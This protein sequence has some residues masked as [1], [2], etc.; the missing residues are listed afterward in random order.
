M[1]DDTF[2]VPVRRSLVSRLRNGLVT[3]GD[4]RPHYVVCGSDPLVYTVLEELAGAGQRVRVTAIVPPTL[5]SDV[6]DLT[7]IRGVRVVHAERLDER[8]FRSAGLA[9]ADALA[10]IHP[11]DVANLHSALCAQAV[12]PDL[13]LVIRMFNTSLGFGVK[14]LFADCAILSDASMAAPAFVASALGEVAPTFF[15]HARR[16]LHL[17]R[18]E[19]VQ[20]E[21]VV[22]LMATSTGG[23]VQVLPPETPP[24]E[25]DPTDLVLAEATGRPTGATVAARRLV[26]TRRRKR[27]ALALGR[28]IRAALNRKLG[29]ALLS[30]LVVLMASGA[31]LVHASNDVHGFW[32]SVY[33]TLLTAVGSSDV[34]MER[35]SIAQF[36][37]L[38][39]TLSGLALLP[40]ITAAVVEGVVNARLALSNGTVRKPQEGHIVVVGLG[41]V[42]TRVIR[43]LADFGIEVV[44]IDR[45]ADA[46]GVKA[47][48]QLG[49]P[50]IVGD[51]AREETLRAA[52]VATCQALVVLSTDDTTNLQAALNARSIRPDLWV[53]LRLFD[54]DFAQRVEKAFDINVSRSVSYL[55]APAFAAAMLDRQVL[56]T[57]PVDRHVLQ[58]AEV[59]VLAGSALEGASLDRADAPYGVRVIGLTPT[60]DGVLDWTPDGRQTLAAGARILVVARRAGLR[61]L[62]EQASPPV[63]ALPTGDPAAS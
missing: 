50:V 5:R 18:R 57:I 21:H 60:A 22:C 39:L 20:P 16:T 29:I 28:A 24:G 59:Q 34:E 61:A 17:A 2:R 42:G 12:E 30:T 9:G 23:R 63:P 52:S 8:V 58:V 38:L 15:R 3:A 46:F 26:R 14:P 11:D 32:Q 45:K 31:V 35:N 33:I 27:P 43:Q 40:L 13:R 37:Q 6:P 51:A 10:L 56:A 25:T 48:E 55:A 53:V 36:A 49:I 19:D 4:V 1:A 7:T 41:S 47:A 62:V 54:G 44:A